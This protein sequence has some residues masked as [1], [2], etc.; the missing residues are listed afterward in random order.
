MEMMRPLP[1]ARMLIREN[2]WKRDRFLGENIIQKV[3]RGGEGE[4][5]KQWNR[6]RKRT[7]RVRSHGN[8]GVG[9]Y[10]KEGIN[11]ILNICN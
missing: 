1:Q 9:S 11:T 6:S 5:Q 4:R 7:A 2:K 8:Y 10:K 3:K